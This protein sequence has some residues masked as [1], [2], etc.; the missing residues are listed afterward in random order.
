MRTAIVCGLLGGLLMGAPVVRAEPGEG[1]YALGAIGSTQYGFDCW[2]Q[3]LSCEGGTGSARKIVLGWTRGGWG[4]ELMGVDFGRASTQAS[5]ASLPGETIR[6]RALGL[7]WV[8]VVQLSGPFRLSGRLGIARTRH[9]RTRETAMS[10]W[11]P[12]V[13]LG[14][15]WQF[16]PGLG[17]EFAWDLCTGE[18]S[19]SGTGIASAYTL[20]L[21]IGF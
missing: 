18:G 13:G 8:G 11:S 1:L 19:D 17:V 12:S 10:V 4:G 15:L 16:Q 21:R 20:G 9:E 5:I 3:P 14:I 6:L 7:S 2:A